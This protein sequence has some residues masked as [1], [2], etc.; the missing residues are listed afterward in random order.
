MATNPDRGLVAYDTKDG[1]RWRVYFTPPG[2]RRQS[3]SFTRKDRARH[4]RDLRDKYGHERA[5]SW[6]D[7]ADAATRPLITLEQA[8]H[9]WLDTLTRPSEATKYVYRLQA[10][11]SW[12][13]DLGDMPVQALTQDDVTAWVKKRTGAPVDGKLPAPATVRQEL[14]RLHSVLED[15]R[16]RGEITRSPTDGITLPRKRSDRVKVISL[17]Q[18]QALCVEITRPEAKESPGRATPERLAS[19]GALVHF[20]GATGCRWSEATAL[21]WDNVDWDNA[22]ANI[23]E[24]W[25]RGP[26]GQATRQV[27]DPKSAASNRSVSLYSDT[28]DVLK[29][30]YTR[31]GDHPTGLV[32]P[33][34]LDNGVVRGLNPT[35]FLQDHWHPARRRLGLPEWV[36]PHVLRHS[37][38]SWLLAAGAPVY[39]VSRRAGHETTA[40]T[41]KVYGHW[42]PDARLLTDEYVARVM[43]GSQRPALGR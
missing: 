23:T 24:A 16:R 30:Q 14:G 38:I 9:R 4:F 36:T 34:R 7:S 11:R 28:I 31:S 6:Y 10:Q 20:L 27:G 18:W 43:G 3:V 39:L 25:N 21:R 15:C 29:E 37:H 40:V 26:A 8:L 12:V 35:S 19:H 33:G 42:I 1:P 17:E 22:A 41:E 13:R 32:F 2:E 5:L